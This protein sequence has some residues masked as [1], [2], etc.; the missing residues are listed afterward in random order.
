MTATL[1]VVGLGS[2]DENQLTLGALKALKA[3]RPL[4]LRT[5]RHPVCVWLKAEGIRCEAFDDVYEAH[6]TFEATYEAIV[7]RLVERLEAG[8]SLTYAVPGHP[9]VAEATV[10]ALLREAGERGFHVEVVGGDSF[11]DQVF[12]RLG[13]DPIEGFQLLDAAD[14]HAD[15]L[16]PAIHTVIAQ[17]YDRHVASEVKLALMELYPDDYPVVAAHELG[18]AGSE[19][20]ERLPLYELDRSDR[21]GNMSVV[22]IPRSADERLQLRSFGKLHE[23]VSVLRSPEGCPW[24]REQTHAS[25]RGNFIEETYEALEALDSGDPDAMREELGDVLLQIML[26]AQMEEEAGMFTARD[27][28]AGLSEKLIRRHPHVFGGQS[29]A[30]AEEALTVWR[31]AKRV[32]KGEMSGERETSLLDGVAHGMPAMLAAWKLQKKA[33]KV[34]FDWTSMED[35]L[36]KAEEEINEMRQLIASQTDDPGLGD[37][38]NKDEE[39]REERKEEAGDLLFA[40]VNAA[41]FWGIDPEAALAAANRKFTS[42]FRYIERKLRQAGHSPEHAGIDE[43]ERLWQEAKRLGGDN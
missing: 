13:F 19:T 36:A 7:Q 4:M 40:A 20:I 26:H 32:E 17:V 35:V 41:R 1:T 2:G 43:M 14:L 9:S 11:L 6:P 15:A 18:V 30:N 33:A 39:R 8:E 37:E 3:E 38:A 25:I 34:G 42:R 10:R 22:W 5:E 12:L 16:R 29:A 24:D 23:I 31:E 27:V 21:F 28:I